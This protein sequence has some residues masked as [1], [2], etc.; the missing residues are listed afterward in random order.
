[1]SQLLLMLVYS[2][3]FLPFLALNIYLLIKHKKSRK[4]TPVD[5]LF[6]PLTARQLAHKKGYSYQYVKHVLDLYDQIE[7]GKLSELDVARAGLYLGE[8]YPDDH[9]R[10]MRE[11]RKSGGQQ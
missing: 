8:M 11:V 10:G 2:A 7:E 6:R 4:S 9:A 3:C 1:M 5:K